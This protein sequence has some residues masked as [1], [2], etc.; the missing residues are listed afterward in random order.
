MISNF[1]LY[2]YLK[3]LIH[4][5]ILK[6]ELSHPSPLFNIYKYI[7]IYWDIY[8]NFKKQKKN[9]KNNAKITNPSKTSITNSQQGN[10]HHHAI[11]PL[12]ISILTTTVSSK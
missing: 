4:Q 5:I 2:F 12:I 11:T 7:F 1:I 8:S 3:V 9:P 6:Y 10:N